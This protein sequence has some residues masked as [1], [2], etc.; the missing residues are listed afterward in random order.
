[1]VKAAPDRYAAVLMDVQMPEMDGL[2]ATRAIR[3][4]PMPRRLPILAMTANAMKADLDA[5]LAAGMD[6]HV[7]KPIERKS[8]LQ[9]LRRWLPARLP[10]S[11]DGTPGPRPRTD[12]D[13][14]TLEGID[15][16]G[17]LERLGLEFES[18]QRMLIRFAD[19]KSAAFDPLRAALAAG[20]SEAVAKHAH[21]I[22]GAAGNLGA[23]ALHAAAKA[24]ERA[25]RAGEK[26]L[27]ALASDL[28]A[29]A[30]VVFRS[31]DT[32]RRATPPAATE[33]GQLSVPAEAWTALTRLQTALGDF[34]LSAA[35]SALA[36]LD[37]IAMP[38]AAHVMAQLRRHID[39]YEYDEARVIATRLLEQIGSQVP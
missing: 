28:E 18:F 11:E 39:N 17:S 21:A 9:T 38:G 5:C 34:D 27:A 30:T 16:A 13:T 23:N 31:I 37:G 10:S 6:D 8:L 33:P 2:A 32:L 4:I 3:D 19:G 24:L 25:G 7:T 36:E 29:R 1:M 35:T 26:D 12:G 22:A 15:V 20:D 14:P